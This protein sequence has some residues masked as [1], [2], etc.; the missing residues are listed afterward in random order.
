[1][2]SFAML[3]RPIESVQ[4]KITRFGCNKFFVPIQSY[5]PCSAKIVLIHDIAIAVGNENDEF[6]NVGLQTG[7][8]N[9]LE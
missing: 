4:A 6:S 1:M 5:S 9:M 7:S 3:N 2:G 8:E